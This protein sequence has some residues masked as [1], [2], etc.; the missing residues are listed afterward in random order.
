[1]VDD[2]KHRRLVDL[3]DLASEIDFELTLQNRG[4]VR[5]CLDMTGTLIGELYE[6]TFEE[7]NRGLDKGED[8]DRYIAQ[9]EIAWDDDEE[10]PEQAGI[11]AITIRYE[12]D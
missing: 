5:K 1:M 10:T 8:P 2:T 12:F 7:E 6:L 4:F 9:E 3:L 11:R